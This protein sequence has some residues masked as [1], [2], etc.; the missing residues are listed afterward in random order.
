[1]GTAPELLRSLDLFSG[2]GGITHALRGVALPAAYCEIDPFATS[3]LAA[4][5]A[6]GSLPAAPL[7]PDVGVLNAAWLRANNDNN[8]TQPLVD[9]VVGGF[10]IR[11]W[12]VGR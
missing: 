2:L 7:C 5:M 6:D 12:W 4:R 3:V 8:N 10:P 9:M 11:R 1:M